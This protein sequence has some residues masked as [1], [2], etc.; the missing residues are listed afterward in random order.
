MFF[1]LI[2]TQFILFDVKWFSDDGIFSVIF[3]TALILGNDSMI[4]VS[5]MPFTLDW[6]IRMPLH[7]EKQF[8]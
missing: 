5:F 3:P 6:R 2:R 4:A 7:S 8:N 1:A